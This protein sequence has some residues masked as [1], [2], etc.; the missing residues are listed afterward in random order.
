MLIRHTKN[1]RSN[2]RAFTG[3]FAAMLLLLTQAHETCYAEKTDKGSKI[4]INLSS[5]GNDV[6]FDTGNI[7]VPH[8]R[9]V[10]LVFKNKAEPDSEILHNIAILKPGTEKEVLAFFEK[11]DYDYAKVKTHPSILAITPNLNPGE[12]AELLLTKDMLSKPGY[13]PYICLVPGHADMLGM[14]GVLHVKKS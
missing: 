11:H 12:E 1:L 2:A 9:K 3:F 13:Y 14:R 8:G 7:Q 10:R 5:K 4:V 6:A